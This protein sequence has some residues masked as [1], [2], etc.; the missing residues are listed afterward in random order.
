MA[1]PIFESFDIH[2]G[3]T[4]SRWRKWVLRLENLFVAAGYVD[5]TRKRAL[6]LHYG[7]QELYDIYETLEDTGTD[8]ITLKDKLT[9][10]FEPKKNTEYSIYKFRQAKQDNNESI[11]KYVTKLKQL[12]LDC[13]FDDKD[14]EIKSQVIQ[15]CASSRLR[16][17]A[18]KTPAITLKELMDEA[19]VLELSEQQASGIEAAAVDV[20]SKKFFKNP[21]PRHGRSRDDVIP[22][23]NPQQRGSRKCFQCGGNYPHSSACPAKNRKCNKCQKMGHYAKVCRSRFHK[24]KPQQTSVNELQCN[25]SDTDSDSSSQQI[26][27]IKNDSYAKRPEINV[28][29]NGQIV[30]VLID[31]GASVNI[32]SL[33]IAKK[34]GVKIH[35]CN[36]ALYTF[37]SRTKLPVNGKFRATIQH[38]GK[39]DLCDFVVV[40]CQSSILGYKSA[41]DLGVVKIVYSVS[42][43]NISSNTSS[44]GKQENTNNIYKQYPNIFS[45]KLGKMKGVE[46]KLHV[47]DEITPVKQTHRR[48]P[49]HQRKNVEEA[50]KKLIKNDVVEPAVGPTTWINP[51]V[52]VPKRNGIRLCIDMREAN[53]AISR[54]RHL[55]P[56]LDE[57]IHDLNGC[58]YFSKIDLKE[59]YHQLKLHADS[60]HLTTFSTH[61]GLYRYKR[62]SFGINAAAEKFQN[63]IATAISDIRNVRN[64]SDDIICFGKTAEEHD[65]ALHK[66]LKRCE[67]LNLTLNKEKCEFYMKK[68]SFY[69]WVF[70]SEGMNPDPSKVE[71][72][73]NMKTPSSVTQVRS[74][75]GLTNYVARC[76]PMYADV[77][78]P[79][80]HLTKKGVKFEWAEK[81]AK[82]LETIKSKLTSSGVMAFY[83]PNKET[84]LIVD[85]SPFGLGGILTQNGHV[86]AYASKAVSPV[87]ARYCQPEREALALSWAC[88]HF[89][90]YL[91]G[92]HFTIRTDC[93]SLVTIF[94]KPSSQTS[95]RIE[96]MR[97]RSQNFDFTVVYGEGS[98]NPADFFSRYVKYKKAN[99]TDNFVS[100]SSEEYVNMILNKNVPKAIS[101]EEITS[102]TKKDKILSMVM[103]SI[104][105]NKWYLSEEQ[106]TLLDETV[107]QKYNKFCGIKDELTTICGVVAKGHKIVIPESL[108][109]KIVKLA[110]EGHQGM[111]KTKQLLRSKVYFFNMDHLCDDEVKKC[112]KCQVATNVNSREPLQMTKLPNKPWQNLSADFAEVAGEYI[113]VVIDDYSR[114]P[115]T[116]IIRS[117]SAKVVIP[118]FEKIFSMF[119]TPVVVKTDNGPPFNSDDF[120]NFA[121]TFNFKHRKV[122]PAWPEANGEAERFMKTLKKFLH[123]SD[124]WKQ[125]IDSFL[126]V[127]RSTPH[128]TT[129]ISPFKALFNREMKGKFP[130]LNLFVSEEC[131]NQNAMMNASDKIKK[132]KMKQYADKRRNTQNNDIEIGDKVFVKQQKIN[133][134]STPF[135]NKHLT[136]VG[137]NNSMI[138]AENTQ[139]RITRNSSFFKKVNPGTVFNEEEKDNI[140]MDE[141]SDD[142][143][144]TVQNDDSN[145]QQDNDSNDN[146]DIQQNENN[147]TE[148]R[149]SKRTVNR[150][151][152]LIEE[153]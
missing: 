112:F 88:H 94:N 15:C 119:D 5:K 111:S 153:N 108:Q 60:R 143:R 62:L 57:I 7:G 65:T 64:I 27:M 61:V 136:V 91:L 121:T 149:R 78:Q 135:W 92:R 84:E 151:K 33:D 110:H 58:A 140:V 54:E 106:L 98:K 24:S 107:V 55:M 46:V 97:L 113:L 130:Q 71:S 37:N 103:E 43:N 9:E 32:V 4:S 18:L 79:I 114:Y 14:K 129:N 126:R 95:A 6:L 22:K 70:S 40:Q 146:P 148:V 28:K 36:I 127:Y 139:K 105:N 51:V 131:E 35:P 82:A 124:N 96:N 77:V 144:K 20:V 147:N 56:T 115:I 17:K 48:I 1:L 109:E 11:D 49:F 93:K 75:L 125:E 13:D 141:D 128:C 104:N 41:S 25:T 90:M 118:K 86:I 80:R 39:R 69:G 21:Q 50:V 72:I 83:D 152:R 76:I 52:V 85:A 117:T 44:K 101:V 142:N 29:I 150:P 26:F 47:N 8:Y 73:I 10:Y 133:K 123:T 120:A 81:Q 2:E 12:A 87:E 138:T 67:E 63:V 132:L 66:L 42:E 34:L 19:H 116:E 38:K 23:P 102:E 89:R 16:R 99:P 137:K 59:G 45:G 122:T 3:N 68:I 145:V 74:L 31:T 53:L 30:K 100:M 134:F